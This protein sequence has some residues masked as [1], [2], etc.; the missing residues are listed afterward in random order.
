MRSSI[1]CIALGLAVSATIGCG[2]DDS[3]SP[4]APAAATFKGYDADE[5]GEIRIEHVRLP[6]GKGGAVNFTRIV[7]Y[8]LAS[9]GSTKFFSFPMVPGCTDTTNKKNWPVATN[10]IGERVY[11]DPGN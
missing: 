3:P 5:G 9:A 6:D 10:P 7:G 1:A 2:G 11:L 8:V 4:D